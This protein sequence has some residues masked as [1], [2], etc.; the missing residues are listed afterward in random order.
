MTFRRTLLLLLLLLGACL[1]LASSPLLA[2]EESPS[3]VAETQSAA[4]NETPAYTLADG[5]FARSR[6]VALGRD[7]QVDG[8]AMSHAVAISGDAAGD[9]GVAGDGHRVAHGLAVH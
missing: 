1:L 3:G 9:P 2:Q 7:L 5:S 8:Q 4:A 6:V